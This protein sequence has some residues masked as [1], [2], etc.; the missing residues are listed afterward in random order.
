MPTAGLSILLARLASG[1]GSRNKV[2]LCHKLLNCNDHHFNG[3]SPTPEIMALLK[4]LERFLA[5][6]TL[7]LDGCKVLRV[8]RVLLGFD[9]ARIVSRLARL[10]VKFGL[11]EKSNTT[12]TTLNADPTVTFAAESRVEDVQTRWCVAFLGIAFGGAWTLL[13]SS[14]PET[15]ARW[16]E[17]RTHVDRT[18]GSPSGEELETPRL[19]T[20]PAESRFLVLCLYRSKFAQALPMRTGYPS[21]TSSLGLRAIR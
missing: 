9:F 15:T 14:F 7:G 13:R 10:A 21:S 17:V 18:V 8:K 6:A 19:A 5:H 4:Q 11:W 16:S 2:R 12:W 20:I 1:L 3:A